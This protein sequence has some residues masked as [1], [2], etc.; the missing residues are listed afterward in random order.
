MIYKSH[1]PPCNKT[2]NAGFAAWPGTEPLL[3]VTVWQ[4]RVVIVYCYEVIIGPNR[5]AGQGQSS[6]PLHTP[7]L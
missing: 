2:C 1:T 5:L 3:K 4:G 6:L 7:I